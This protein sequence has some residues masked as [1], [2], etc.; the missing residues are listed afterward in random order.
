[1]A[2]VRVCACVSVAWCVYIAHCERGSRVCVH[3]FPP[4]MCINMPTDDWLD[5]SHFQN[6]VESIFAHAHALT[7]S[8]P[9]LIRLLMHKYCGLDFAVD[10]HSPLCRL[11]FPS[12]FDDSFCFCFASSFCDYACILRVVNVKCCDCHQCSLRTSLRQSAEGRSRLCAM[13]IVIWS[14][15]RPPHFDRIESL[16]T[17]V[18]CQWQWCARARSLTL[19]TLNNVITVTFQIP[20]S[21]TM[22]KPYG[23]LLHTHNRTFASVVRSLVHSHSHVHYPL[24]RIA[25]TA[26]TAS[27]RWCN[28]H[29]SNWICFC[30][31][32]SFA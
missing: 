29:P 12:F 23:A 6:K 13:R 32:S 2:G 7:T 30:F 17:L 8:Q 10:F 26:A 21:T 20:M 15:H 27:T 9:T 1:M 11:R 16:N 3:D 5:F 25:K 24:V 31:S 14:K 28:F 22:T 19:H 4:G 18:C